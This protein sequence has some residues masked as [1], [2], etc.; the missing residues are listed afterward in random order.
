MET[1]QESRSTVDMCSKQRKRAKTKESTLLPA[2]EAND[3][4]LIHNKYR[5]HPENQIIR[6]NTAEF[7][8]RYV[9]QKGCM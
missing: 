5:L 8:P 9:V 2:G 6:I 3:L 7:W 4:D 1:A